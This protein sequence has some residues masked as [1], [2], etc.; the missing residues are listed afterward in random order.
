[1]MNSC[2][3][4]RLHVVQITKARVIQLVSQR[5]CDIIDSPEATEPGWGFRLA[6]SFAMQ[7]V[8]KAEY[9]HEAFDAVECFSGGFEPVEG[10][11]V[12][13]A[14]REQLLAFLG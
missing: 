7:H 13:V 8:I 4:W 9:F 11:V 10:L 12:G 14:E 3:Q 6:H 5:R 1:M 2:F